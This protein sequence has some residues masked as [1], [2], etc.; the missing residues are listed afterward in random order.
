MAVLDILFDQMAEMTLAQD[1]HAVEALGLDREHEPL[2]VRVEIGA[3]GRE[4][5]LD[6][7]DLEQLAEILGVQR[8]PD[9]G[10]G[11]ACPEGTH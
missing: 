3:S 10:S 9:H 5:G 6:S 2:R 8:D 7:G 11:I 4:S 1:D